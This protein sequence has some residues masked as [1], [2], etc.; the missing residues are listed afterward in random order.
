MSRDSRA[1]NRLSRF[2]VRVISINESVD[3][4]DQRVEFRG[5]RG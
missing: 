5:E 3:I 1:L 2:Y 4:V